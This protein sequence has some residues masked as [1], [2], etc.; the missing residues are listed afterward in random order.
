MWTYHAVAAVLRGHSLLAA[1]AR[2]RPDRI[3]V[4]GI[5]WG[6][7]LTCIVAGLDDRLKVAVPVYGCGFLHENSA[8]KPERFDKMPADRRGPLGRSLRPVDVPARRHAARSCSSTAPTTSPTRWTA[9]R[10]RT[11][12]PVRGPATRPLCVTVRMPHGHEQGWAPKEIGLFVDSRPEGGRAPAQARPDHDRGRPGR[13]ARWLKDPVEKAEIL[14]AVHA[15]PWPGRKWTAAP[16]SVV[17]D[18]VGA[19]L[20]ADRPLVVFLNVVD[21][22]GAVASSP[23]AIAAEDP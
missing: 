21:R 16:A 9:T 3:G 6:G 10:S 2:G 5:S 7:Y 18:S 15:G 1:P 17:G 12:V 20:P 4:T 14:Y 8:W 22:R 19:D 23:H 11:G 13:A